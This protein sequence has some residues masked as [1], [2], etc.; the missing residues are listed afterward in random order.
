MEKLSGI[1]REYYPG[2]RING[3]YQVLES[4]QGGMG[5]VYLCFDL[6][7]KTPVA[8]KTIRPDLFRNR[9]SLETFR[10]EAMVWVELGKHK[11]IVNAWYIEEINHRPAIAMECISGD[12][13]YGNDLSCYIG[14]YSFE[15]EQIIALAIQFCE[16]MLH[17]NRCFEEKGL[18][19]VH[20]DLKPQNIMLTKNLILKIADF[21][22][23]KNSFADR[24][25]GGT[26]GYMSPEQYEGKE[27]D[28]R[29]DI[30]SFGC[31]LFELLTE[32]RRPYELTK[33]ELET[34][35]PLKLGEV[36][37][38]KHLSGNPA[39]VGLWL[40]ETEFYRDIAEI[41][42]KCLH[43]DR[44][45]RYGSFSQLRDAL[46]AIYLKVSGKAYPK[47]PPMELDVDEII[48]QADSYYKFGQYE[49]ALGFIDKALS[50]TPGYGRALHEKA[51]IFR[52]IGRRDEALDLFDQAI[53]N[54]PNFFY[55]WANKGA[56]L[57][58][59]GRFNEA[60]YCF[61]KSLEINPK[62][63]PAL[64]NKAETLSRLNQTEQVISLCKQAIEI[65]HSYY[66]AWLTMGNAH[67]SR[68]EF[69]EALSAFSHGVERK[70]DCDA[71]TNS[72]GTVFYRMEDYEEALR[73]FK[74]AI[75]LN[76]RYANAF[77]NLG[78]TYVKQGD[79]ERAMEYYFMAAAYGHQP[80]ERILQAKKVNTA[81][82][83]TERG[84]NF[85][86]M[87]K[88]EPAAVF[89][90]K[91]IMIEQNYDQAWFFLGVTFN[92]LHQ[93]EDAVNCYKVAAGLGNRKA[94]QLL[95]KKYN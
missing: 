3:R 54:I 64:I 35:D 14:R 62:C 70:P 11:S 18:P 48:S 32:G 15:F 84:C 92:N 44:N 31:I 58:M 85:I 9:E 45:Q 5:I 43:K 65:D 87:A 73:Y 82:V 60:L 76:P 2:D 26:M 38:Q 52:K 80:A 23:V 56:T 6:V 59:L 49:T 83:W 81:E 24:S 12:Q 21:G 89:L 77:N 42:S 19:F 10:Q 30:Y 66:Q 40:P 41:V 16:G 95:D 71:L 53:K 7:A 27:L 75:T 13:D 61:D 39:R 93:D 68:G 4:K 67:L 1:D 50:L 79:I 47:P 78:S 28:T 74:K 88:F 34:V 94:Q 69:S 25:W 29:S 20:R 22:L 36:L 72:I 63:C 91:A 86:K 33:L 17:A 57:T 8:F 37:Q 90:Q 51:L 46:D 55:A